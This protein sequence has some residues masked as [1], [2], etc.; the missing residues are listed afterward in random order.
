MYITSLVVLTLHCIIS[1]WYRLWA[2]DT[3]KSRL[4]LLLHR[5]YFQRSDISLANEYIGPSPW[6]IGSRHRAAVT[7]MGTRV[8]DSDFSSDSSHYFGT[9]TLLASCQNGL[10]TWLPRLYS[11][12]VL[13][14]IRAINVIFVY[15]YLFYVVK[16]ENSIT[17]DTLQVGLINLCTAAYVCAL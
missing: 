11:D 7:H 9:C 2:T 8:N 13:A 12:F 1:C 5:A 17:P 3:K 4:N 6:V 15:I 10:E 14:T 16:F